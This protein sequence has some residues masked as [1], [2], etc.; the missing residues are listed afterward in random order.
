MAHNITAR[1]RVWPERHR[2]QSC[3]IALRYTLLSGPPTLSAPYRTTRAP[4]VREVHPSMPRPHRPPASRAS[5]GGQT[6]TRAASRFGTSGCAA[7]VAVLA[8]IAAAACHRAFPSEQR[9][10][11]TE[12]RFYDHCK[13]GRKH[14]MINIDWACLGPERSTVMRRALGLEGE[15][16]AQHGRVPSWLTPAHADVVRV[17][18]CVQ[19]VRVDLAC[20][21]CKSTPRTPLQ[22]AADAETADAQ[23]RRAAAAS[24]E[25]RESDAPA[26][27]RGGSGR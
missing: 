24:P 6:Q 4:A 10:P 12:D 13:E 15:A 23:A 22:Q 7:V 19:D 11:P 9:C 25:A 16:Q 21:H 26:D 1:L 14:Y 20:W 2:A 3:A 17:S 5:S 27:R 8:A 18:P